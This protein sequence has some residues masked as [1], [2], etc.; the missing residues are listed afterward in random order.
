MGNTLQAFIGSIVIMYI[1]VTSKLKSYWYKEDDGNYT[2]FRPN[3]II[4][5]DDEEASSKVY[6]ITYL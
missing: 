5:K 1:R 6:F 2:A 3:E 4:L